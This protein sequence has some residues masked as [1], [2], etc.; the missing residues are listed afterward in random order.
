MI[1][2][3]QYICGEEKLNIAEDAL[4][5]LVELSDGDLRKSITR[6][7]S[8]SMGCQSI[9]SLQVVELCGQID[10][11]VVMQFIEA[12][13]KPKMAAM[14]SEVREF[15]CGGYSST[16]FL[17]QLAPHVINDS[18]LTGVQKAKILQHIA[19]SST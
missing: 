18:K 14:E 10:D 4:Q 8:L 16:Q 15:V 7:Q 11:A 13:R 12:C 6:L 5:K 9:S 2:R 3:L 19:V 1:F 17:R